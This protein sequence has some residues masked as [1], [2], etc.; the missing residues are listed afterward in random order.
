MT[1]Y[2]WVTP[3]RLLAGWCSDRAAIEL[4]LP[5]CATPLTDAGLSGLRDV[6]ENTAISCSQKAELGIGAIEAVQIAS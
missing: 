5:A 1:R 6:A 2:P 4:S 3:R